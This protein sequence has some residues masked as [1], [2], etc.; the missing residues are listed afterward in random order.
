MP[1]QRYGSK[2][3]W[4]IENESLGIK[5]IKYVRR[6]PTGLLELTCVVE[7]TGTT[8]IQDHFTA[9]AEELGDI[10]AAAQ[11]EEKMEEERSQA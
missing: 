7:K 4:E 2:I 3:I 6:Y 10:L 11:W 1:K 9:T 8:M 5:E